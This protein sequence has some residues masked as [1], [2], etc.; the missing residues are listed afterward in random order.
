M[1]RQVDSSEIC[2]QEAKR[3]RGEADS[4]RLLICSLLARKHKMET[5]VLRITTLFFCS[6]TEFD[7]TFRLWFI[8]CYAIPTRGREGPLGPFKG[9]LWGLVVLALW[10]RRCSNLWNSDCRRRSKRL[11]GVP[12]A[13]DH[14]ETPPWILRK[15]ADRLGLSS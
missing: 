12:P 8:F 4:R 2:V 11:D 5:L 15:P 1:S 7:K 6:I 13:R 10:I 3:P 9:L 14:Q